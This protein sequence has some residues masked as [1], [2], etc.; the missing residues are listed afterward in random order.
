[1]DKFVNISIIIGNSYNQEIKA[2]EEYLFKLQLNKRLMEL[3]EIF[4]ELFDENKL[5]EIKKYQFHTKKLIKIHD[6]NIL[7]DFYEE[8]DHLFIYA[9]LI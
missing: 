3:K 7:N 1:M 6:N 8:G 5:S 2:G 4:Y 9:L